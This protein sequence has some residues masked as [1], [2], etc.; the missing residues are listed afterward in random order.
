MYLS[1]G[2]SGF[3]RRDHP[4]ITISV[5]NRGV[6]YLLFLFFVLYYD[7]AAGFRDRGVR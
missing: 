1:R 6:R 2:I 5:F 4:K 3:A 7:K